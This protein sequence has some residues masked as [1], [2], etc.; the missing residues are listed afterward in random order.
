MRSI[1]PLFALAFVA[2]APL[3][4]AETVPLP[5]FQSVELRGGGDILVVPGRVQRVTLVEGSTRFTRLH[6]RGDGQ[7][8][9]DT[10]NERC[11]HDYQLQVRIESP[12]VPS[13]AI[14]GGGTIRTA[15]GFAPQRELSAAI[16]G[17]GKID[18]RSVEA[19]AVNGGGDIFVRPRVS[20]SAAVNGGGDVHYSGTPQVSMAVRGGGDVR[21]DD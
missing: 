3:L 13:V 6:M 17:G 18:L 19:A 15:A 12:R 8:E 4:A 1:A 5:A 14:A 10:C 2:S 7:L 9:I 21:R 16:K 11:P 20:L